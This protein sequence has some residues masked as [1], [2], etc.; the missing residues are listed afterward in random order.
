MNYALIAAV[1]AR[2]LRAPILSPTFFQGGRRRSE[3]RRSALLV[4]FNYPA[5]AEIPE[6]ASAAGR[7]CVYSPRRR[8][9][10]AASRAERNERE[11]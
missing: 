6:G 4:A 11:V 1:E 8:R 9:V 3:S 2:L 5:A 7:K 10:D